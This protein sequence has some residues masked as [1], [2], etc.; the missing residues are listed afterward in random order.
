M[1][2]LFNLYL[3]ERFGSAVEWAL[4]EARA[5][6]PSSR[7]QV[8][9]AVLVY[10]VITEYLVPYDNGKSVFGNDRLEEWKDVVRFFR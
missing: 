1:R 10:E 2:R 7:S 3:Q 4:I 5:E 9:A 6:N 8:S